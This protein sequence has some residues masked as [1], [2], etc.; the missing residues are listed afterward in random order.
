MENSILI[1]FRNLS[2]TLHSPAS[3]VHDFNSRRPKGPNYDFDRA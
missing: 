3:D 2:K 1:S